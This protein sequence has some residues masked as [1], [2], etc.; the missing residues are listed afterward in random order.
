LYRYTAK[1][2]QII[3]RLLDEMR[4]TLQLAKASEEMMGSIKKR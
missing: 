3:Q 2:E 4:E 1:I